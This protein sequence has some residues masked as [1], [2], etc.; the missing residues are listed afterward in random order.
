[1]V[2]RRC[3][4]VGRFLTAQLPYNLTSV[5]SDAKLGFNSLDKIILTHRHP[6]TPG[7]A[8]FNTQESSLGLCLV[9]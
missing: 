9:P 2:E 1:M 3:Q 8:V 5:P 6:S 4:N 7:E